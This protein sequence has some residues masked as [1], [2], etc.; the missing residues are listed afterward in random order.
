MKSVVKPTVL[1][2][3]TPEGHPAD[4]IPQ[5]VMQVVEVQ[6]KDSR[7]ITYIVVASAFYIDVFSLNIGGGVPSVYH[8]KKLKI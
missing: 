7:T 1:K 4:Q 5:N 8:Q 3:T 6:N 2:V